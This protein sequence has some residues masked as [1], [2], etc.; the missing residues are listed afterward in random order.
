MFPPIP[1][2]PWSAPKWHKDI[3][4]YKDSEFKGTYGTC[5]GNRNVHLAARIGGCLKR[6]MSWQQVEVEAF[7]E[8]QACI[9]PLTENETRNVLNSL[10]R[11]I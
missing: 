3:K 4:E 5:K 11:Y 7:K 2:K 1:V 10:R 6:G 9:P 8:A